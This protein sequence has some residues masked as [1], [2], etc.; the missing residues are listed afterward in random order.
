MNSTP[1]F[2]TW[3][4]EKTFG[5]RRGCVVKKGDNRLSPFFNDRL[6]MKK[7]AWYVMEK[8][9]W[10]GVFRGSFHRN[11][12]QDTGRPSLS[13]VHHEINNSGRFAHSLETRSQT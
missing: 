7:A 3:I 9:A 13:R 5:F 2:S 11:G 6:I 10:Y 8:A 12:A 4:A 1:V